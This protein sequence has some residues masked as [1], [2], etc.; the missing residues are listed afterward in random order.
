M[1]LALV[2]LLLV[3]LNTFVFSMGELWG[4]NSERRLFDQHVRAVTRFLEK[5]LR[6]AALPPTRPVGEAAVMAREVRQQTGGREPLLT[7][8]LREGS[9][10]FSWPGAPLPDVLCAL[11]QRRGEGLV[12]LWHAPWEERFLT[13]PPRETLLT[14]YVTAMSYDYY[15]VDFKRWERVE[16]LRQESNGTAEV[17]QRLRLLFTYRNLTREALIPLPVVPQGLPP[18]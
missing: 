2:G 7:F 4:R 14:P 11:A 10:L 13:E 3:A 12:L 6:A 5:E 1:A 17:P 9:R 16:R 18:F 15:D 8:Q